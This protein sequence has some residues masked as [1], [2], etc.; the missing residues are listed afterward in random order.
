[1]GLQQQQINNAL[2]A[3]LGQGLFGLATTPF[4]GGAAT[5]GLLGLIK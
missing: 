4:G 1:M 2:A 3:S 5:N